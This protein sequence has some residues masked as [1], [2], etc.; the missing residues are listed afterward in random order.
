MAS[1][2]ELLAKESPEMQARVA[3]RVEA[4]SIKIT[5]RQLRE[6]L[7]FSQTALA[8]AIGISRLAANRIEQ[9]DNN[10]RLSTLQRYV[11]A[12]VGELSIDVK[13]PSGKRIAYTL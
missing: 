2:K 6:E 5:L 8:S 1:D 11:K 10:T 3:T 12:L 7:N 13:L 4:E 9:Q